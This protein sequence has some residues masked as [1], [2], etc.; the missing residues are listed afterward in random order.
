[1]SNE[2]CSKFS[3]TSANQSDRLSI[4]VKWLEDNREEDMRSLKSMCSKN[5]LLLSRC[6]RQVRNITEAG[7]SLQILRISRACGRRM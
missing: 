6:C 4:G 1:M 7:H 3:G 5:I 2:T